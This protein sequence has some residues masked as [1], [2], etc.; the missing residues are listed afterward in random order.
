M[1]F[2]DLLAQNG[3][4]DGQNGG[5]GGATLTPTNSF[6][7]L[8]ILTSVPL[9]HV[10][11][12]RIRWDIQNAYDLYRCDCGL[13]TLNSRPIVGLVVRMQINTSTYSLLVNHCWLTHH[14]IHIIIL[15]NCT[16]VVKI[17]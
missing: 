10:H 1:D 7:L 8:R 17:W 9:K 3:G 6:L 11:A 5:M 15:T 16:E 4:F 13:L 14:T 2:Q 12:H